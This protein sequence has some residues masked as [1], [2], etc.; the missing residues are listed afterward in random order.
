MVK[1]L[2]RSVQRAEPLHKLRVV[3]EL[4]AGFDGAHGG[5]GVKYMLSFAREITARSCN[6]KTPTTPIVIIQRLADI[7]NIVEGL[8]L[9][10]GGFGV[11]L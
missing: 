7:L 5:Y 9:A 10:G 6:S 8:Q 3:H 1:L 2:T 11:G 4:L